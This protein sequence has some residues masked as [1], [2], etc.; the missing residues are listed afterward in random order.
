[1][2][3]RTNRPESLWHGWITDKLPY[4]SG[5][6]TRRI[7]VIDRQLGGPGRSENRNHNFNHRKFLRKDVRKN[8]DMLM[9][10]PSEWFI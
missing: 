9:A 1:L 5:L 4:G 7:Q 8:D 6:N 3:V 10:V 2:R